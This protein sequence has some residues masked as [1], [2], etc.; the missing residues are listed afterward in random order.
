MVFV[1]VL[2]ASMFIQSLVTPPPPRVCVPF[3]KTEQ[4][5]GQLNRS[6]TMNLRDWNLKGDS[7]PPGSPPCSRTPGPVKGTKDLPS[8]LTGP[9][10]DGPHQIGSHGPPPSWKQ[11]FH[12]SVGRAKG[13][14]R[15]QRQVLHTEPCP[16]FRFMKKIMNRSL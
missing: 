6:E 5:S 9:L 10:V 16:N 11:I 7:G 2:E 1:G 13:F 12:S 3:S 8:A 4:P 14:V 15:E